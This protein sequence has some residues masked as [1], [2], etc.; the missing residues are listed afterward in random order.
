VSAGNS[1]GA[2]GTPPPALPSRLAKN[3]S[4]PENVYL[5]LTASPARFIIPFLLGLPRGPL[6]DEE[7]K[8]D[9]GAL[10]YPGHAYLGGKPPRDPAEFLAYA[11]NQP[12]LDPRCGGSSLG[13][14]GSMGVSQFFEPTMSEFN[15]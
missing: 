6:N 11:L 9:L 15:L 14:T 1:I 8:F 2:N 7:L 5:E 3:A 4:S 10:G 13:E 12:D